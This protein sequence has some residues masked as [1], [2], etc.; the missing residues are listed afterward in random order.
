M[1][2][3][4]A[5]TEI[6]SSI[7]CL[8]FLIFLSFFLMFFETCVSQKRESLDLTPDTFFLMKT[9]FKYFLFVVLRRELALT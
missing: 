5:A 8:Q 3:G 6:L 2:S 4:N 1:F 7:F 9:F